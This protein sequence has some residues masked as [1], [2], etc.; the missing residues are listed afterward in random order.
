M[1]LTDVIMLAKHY[2]CNLCSW[3]WYSIAARKPDCCPNRECRSREWDGKK[4]KRKPAPKPKIGIEL[5][6]PRRIK[7]VEVDEY[8]F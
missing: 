6:K 2:Q 8:G 1:I 4:K 7:N 3:D 5:P